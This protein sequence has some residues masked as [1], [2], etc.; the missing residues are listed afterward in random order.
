[1]RLHYTLEFSHVVFVLVK[2]LYHY[3]ATNVV[4]YM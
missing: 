3:N 2:L 4:T 1:M